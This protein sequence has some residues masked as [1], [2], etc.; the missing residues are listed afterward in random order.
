MSTFPLISYQG[1]NYLLRTQE[2]RLTQNKNDGKFPEFFRRFTSGIWY[3][4]FSFRKFLLK[5]FNLPVL[6]ILINTPVWIMI[7]QCTQVNH[8]EKCQIFATLLV[9]HLLVWSSTQQLVNYIEIQNIFV[10]TNSSSSVIVVMKKTYRIS[11]L[12]AI[13]LDAN[14]KILTQTRIKNSE[15]LKFTRNTNY[16]RTIKK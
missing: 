9:L 1:N 12:L 3:R 16:Y 2:P 7:Y 11:S 13:H 8:Q 15:N 10:L 6:R 4:Y 14:T 5:I